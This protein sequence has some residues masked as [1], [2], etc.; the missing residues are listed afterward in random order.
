M[1]PQ[2]ILI[3][4]DHLFHYVTTLYKTL[5]ELRHGNETGLTS[6]QQFSV[7]R[8]QPTHVQQYFGIITSITEDCKHHP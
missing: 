4:K 8:T 2:R 1:H 3:R 6:P 7:S 5:S